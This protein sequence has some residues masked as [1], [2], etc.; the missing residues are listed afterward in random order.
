MWPRAT[1]LGSTNLDYSHW[2]GSVSGRWEFEQTLKGFP[3][4]IFLGVSLFPAF[5]WSFILLFYYNISFNFSSGVIDTYLLQKHI[6][7]STVLYKV[8]TQFVECGI[9]FRLRPQ[10]LLPKAV[11]T[12]R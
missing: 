2:S 11:E 5:F 3:A 9:T 12:P 6:I 10:G 8:G 7:E 1:A 4:N